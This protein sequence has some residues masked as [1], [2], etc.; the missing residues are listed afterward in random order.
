M[1]KLTAEQFDSRGRTRRQYEIEVARV[2]LNAPVTSVFFHLTPVGGGRG[3]DL[4]LTPEA[5]QELAA[6]LTG[7]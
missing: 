4:R 5:A 7:D 1:A 2:P 3:I 6:Q